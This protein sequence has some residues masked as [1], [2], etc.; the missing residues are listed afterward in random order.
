[1]KVS[2]IFGPSLILGSSPN[3]GEGCADLE[4]EVLAV[5]EPLSFFQ[6]SKLLIQ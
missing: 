2:M 3:C 6:T 1:M 4:E 5:S